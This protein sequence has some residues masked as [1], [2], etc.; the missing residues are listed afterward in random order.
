MIFLHFARATALTLALGGTINNALAANPIAVDSPRLQDGNIVPEGP[1]AEALARQA[2]REQAW[3]ER[4]SKFLRANEIIQNLHTAT[5]SEAELLKTELHGL[6]DDLTA[7]N[8]KAPYNFPDHRLYEWSLQIRQALDTQI[9]QLHDLID[10]GPQVE[11][12]PFALENL[13]G[14]NLD[15]RISGL[16]KT[17][18]TVPVTEADKTEYERAFKEIVARI[19]LG[20]VPGYSAQEQTYAP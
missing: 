9:A 2:A 20:Q 6:I 16:F 19:E 4:E 17:L 8:P 14:T 3:L 1:S 10:N 13:E 7:R 15:N 5:G 12:K 18:N 11:T